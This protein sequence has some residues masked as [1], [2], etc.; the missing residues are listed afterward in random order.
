VGTA[1]RDSTRGAESPEG[2]AVRDSTVIS[3]ITLCGL[4][5]EVFMSRSLCPRCSVKKT[6]N[7]SAVSATMVIVRCP[8]FDKEVKK[9]VIS[10][11]AVKGCESSL[12]SSE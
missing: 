10:E 7:F 4:T 6:C 9:H 12:V 3:L 1:P 11:K 5:P 2:A 8:W